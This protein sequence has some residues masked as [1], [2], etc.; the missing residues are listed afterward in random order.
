ML[1]I[2]VTCMLALV[3]NCAVALIEALLCGD[4]GNHN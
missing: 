3:D 4:L 1:K 2:E